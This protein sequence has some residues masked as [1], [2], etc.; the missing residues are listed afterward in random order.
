MENLIKDLRYGVRSLLKQPA[1]T[2]IAVSTLALAIG[3]NTAMF[4]VVNAVL[5]R[6]LPYP[7]ADRIAY[8]EAVNPGRG[9]KESNMSIPD[10]ADWQSQNQV[11]EEMAGFVNGGVILNNND[12]AERLRAAGVSADFF[13]LFRTTPLRGRT[14][15][16]DDAEKGREPVA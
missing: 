2:L 6:P 1:F 7:E 10:F 4:S 11:F 12:E 8:L 15:Q 14:L 3:G 16:A 13:K 9:I 5:L